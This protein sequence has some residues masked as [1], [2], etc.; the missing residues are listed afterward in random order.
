MF[1]MVPCAQGVDSTVC[2][3]LCGNGEIWSW[4]VL[5]G[6]ERGPVGYTRQLVYRPTVRAYIHCT[7][8]C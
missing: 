6:D 3:A 5:R 4:G 7:V 1:V 2:Y 8:C